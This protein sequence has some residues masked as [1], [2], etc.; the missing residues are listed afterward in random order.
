MKFLRLKEEGLEEIEEKS[1][2]SI[3]DN[4]LVK[5]ELEES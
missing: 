3:E 5:R 4:K 1:F 2:I